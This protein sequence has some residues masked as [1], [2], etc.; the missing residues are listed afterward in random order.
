MQ[1]EKVNFFK[2]L[3]SKASNNVKHDN[4]PLPIEKIKNFFE[5]HKNVLT[6]YQ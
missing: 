4:E 2:N 3:D 6:K 1:N 5:I